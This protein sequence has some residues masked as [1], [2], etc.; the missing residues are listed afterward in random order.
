MKKKFLKSVMVATVLS[1]GLFQPAAAGMLQGPSRSDSAASPPPAH[2]YVI[3]TRPDAAHLARIYFEYNNSGKLRRCSLTRAGTGT[4]GQGGPNSIT[5]PR[6]EVSC[7]FSGATRICSG[8]KDWL[9]S[10][11]RLMCMGV[12]G[13]GTYLTQMGL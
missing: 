10:G 9:D 12:R 13:F 2:L 5:G 4:T 11:A 6:Y 3:L 1:L 8:Y 7:S